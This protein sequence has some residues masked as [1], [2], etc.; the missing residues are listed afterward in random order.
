M[1]YGIDAGDRKIPTV[2]IQLIKKYNRDHDKPR[3]GRVTSVFERDSSEDDIL[4]RYS[5]VTA[6]GNEL[7][8]QQAQDIRNMEERYSDI[9][10]KE[11]GLTKLTEFSIETGQNEPIFQRAYN[12]PAALRESIDREIDWLLDKEFITPSSSPWS[13]PMVT[14]REP[15]GTARLCVDLKRSTPLPDKCPFICPVLRRY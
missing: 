4:D 6:S 2:H 5:E 9:L 10:T 13:S 8:E 7:E 12:T 15:D 1:S 11:P 14:V 3:V